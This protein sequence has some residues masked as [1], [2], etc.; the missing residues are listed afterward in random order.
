MIIWVDAHLSPAIAI[1]IT[2]TFNIQALALRD[3][4]LRDAEDSEIFET[5]R[6]QKIIF[7]TKGSDFV[8]LISRLGPL[9]QVIWLT[10]GNTS[11]TRSNSARLTLIPPVEDDNL[12]NLLPDY[13]L[14][15]LKTCQERYLLL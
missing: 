5:A 2:E 4:G 7:I 15:N 13:I 11:N 12:V 10:Y 14:G 6:A 3:V 8:D 9:P 1:W